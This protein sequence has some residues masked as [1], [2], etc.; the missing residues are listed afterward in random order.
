MHFDTHIYCMCI[1]TVNSEA[2]CLRNFYFEID[3][4]VRIAKLRP[5]KHFGKCV[6]Y[7]INTLIFLG[8][9]DSEV[10]HPSF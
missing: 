9:Q 1:N 10:P 2:Y 6:I 8:H 7:A 4:I 3:E 5:G